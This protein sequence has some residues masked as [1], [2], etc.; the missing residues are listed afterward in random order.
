MCVHVWAISFY[1]HKQNRHVPVLSVLERS[2][3][4]QPGVPVA[5]DQRWSRAA[6]HQGRW[7]GGS[8]ETQVSS[9]S[10]NSERRMLTECSERVTV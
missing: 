5:S 2:Q 9:N 4:G 7:Y 10:V 1:N 6:T 8:S 3:R